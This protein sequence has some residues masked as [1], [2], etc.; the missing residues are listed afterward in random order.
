MPISRGPCKEKF[1][2]PS[3]FRIQFLRQG[4]QAGWCDG[5]FAPLRNEKG[6]IVGA[7]VT[8]RNVTERKHREDELQQLSSRLLQSQD[9]ERRR[10]ARD[11]HDSFAQSLLAVNLIWRN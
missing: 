5:D 8:V 1:P 6:E 2:R 4:R 9:E 7:I 3:T 11:L 10:I